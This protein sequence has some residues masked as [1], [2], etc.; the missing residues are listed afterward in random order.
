MIEVEVFDDL[1]GL[2]KGHRVRFVADEDYQTVGSYAYDT[3]EETKAAE[4]FEIEKLDSFE[5]VV[6]GMIEERPCCECGQWIE[7]DS[8]WGITVENSQKA[9]RELYGNV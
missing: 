8:L 4:N 6:L 9:I 5:W 7:V 2:P 3:E 1:E